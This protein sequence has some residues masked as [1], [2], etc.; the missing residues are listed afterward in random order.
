MYTIG[1]LQ[2]LSPDELHKELHDTRRDLFQERTSQAIGQ[3]K[4]P[5]KKKILKKY[6]THILT[7]LSNR[8]S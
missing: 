2:N 1:E 7:V 5:H 3:S 4:T 8:T 6:I